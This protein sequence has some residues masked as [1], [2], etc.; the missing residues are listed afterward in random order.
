[1]SATHRIGLQPTNVNHYADC[2]I[3]LHAWRYGIAK[4]TS[5]LGGV[6]V[7]LEC[8]RCGTERR[9]AWSD[10]TGEMITRHY[11]YPEGYSL[12]ESKTGVPRPTRDELRAMVLA[13]RRLRRR[14]LAQR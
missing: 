10:V 11:V 2:W 1:M 12:A 4:H 9:E 13:N 8:V 3:F 14:A 7:L 5:R 6:P